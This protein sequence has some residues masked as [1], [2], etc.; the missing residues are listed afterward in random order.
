MTVSTWHDLSLISCH[1]SFGLFHLFVRCCSA[2]QTNKETNK[3]TKNLDKLP[4][5][6]NSAARLV[7][8]ASKREH[9]YNYFLFALFRPTYTGFLR[10]TESC[11]RYILILSTTMWSRVLH[12]VSCWSS[13]DV[14]SLPVFP[15]IQWFTFLL[16]F[17]VFFFS[18]FFF[19]FSLLFFSFF[20]SSVSY[21][22]QTQIVSGLC[23]FSYS[24]LDVLNRLLFN[25]RYAQTLSSFK[26]Q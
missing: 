22:D 21:S 14:H 10:L 11:T 23:S 26:S 24:G 9:N 7:C 4:R 19:S 20:F 18:F 25:V 3:Q 15:F 13:S 5:T 2:K 16:F 1:L 17:F 6:M 12:L 8:R